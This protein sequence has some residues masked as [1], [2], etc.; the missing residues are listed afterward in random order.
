M[1]WLTEASRR[2][3]QAYCEGLEMNCPM[4]RI[5][6]GEDG[7]LACERDTNYEASRD[8]RSIQTAEPTLH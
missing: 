8:A 3:W 2:L 6:A 4:R 1:S 7:H 5:S